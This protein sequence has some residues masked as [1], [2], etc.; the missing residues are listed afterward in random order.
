MIKRSLPWRGTMRRWAASIAVLIMAVF[1]ALFAALEPGPEDIHISSAEPMM[2]QDV[3][4]VLADRPVVIEHSGGDF[5]LSAPCCALGVGGTIRLAEEEPDILSEPA[6]HKAWY[7]FK[8]IQAEYISP[9]GE[10]IPHAYSSTPMEAC[11]VLNGLEWQQYQYAPENYQIQYYDDLHNPHSWQRLPAYPSE[12]DPA[13]CAQV[14]RL[15]LFALAV[16]EE[17][18]P[19]TGGAAD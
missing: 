17:A 16:R 9:A 19:L 11:F 3:G 10:I 18:I 4:P 2:V 6:R 7:R 8:V 12:E 15:R 5:V 1:V 14:H 13:V